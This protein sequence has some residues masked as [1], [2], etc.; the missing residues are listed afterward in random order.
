MKIRA[1]LEIKDCK[2]CEYHGMYTVHV[3]ESEELKTVK[4]KIIN[5]INCTSLKLL[6]HQTLACTTRMAFVPTCTC[7][8]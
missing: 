4:K 1:R 3:M 2:K 7:M 5:V 8:I 6:Q